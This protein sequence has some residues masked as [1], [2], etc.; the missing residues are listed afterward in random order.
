MRGIFGRRGSRA[1]R[2]T[3]VGEG[4][5]SKRSGPVFQKWLETGLEGSG[6]KVD[7][8]EFKVY[9]DTKIRFHFSHFRILDEGR[10]TCFQDSPHKCGAAA[11]SGD[12]R[13]E[14]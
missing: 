9:A 1:Y 6:G 10:K 13:D 8:V 7:N 12:K 5:C 11:S 14:L 3:L 4:R 2:D